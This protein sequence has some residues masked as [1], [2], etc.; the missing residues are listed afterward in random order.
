[1]KK[2]VTKEELRDIVSELADIFMENGRYDVNIS[3]AHFSSSDD[4]TISVMDREQAYSV[5]SQ[6]SYTV[7]ERPSDCIDISR[8]VKEDIKR[9]ES[10]IEK[11]PMEI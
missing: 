4:L 5:V 2:Y 6:E 1:M 9:H 10:V 11:E 3:L 7:I 8:C